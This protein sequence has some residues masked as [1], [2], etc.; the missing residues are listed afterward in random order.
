M[1]ESGKA[2]CPMARNGGNN[3]VRS[4]GDRDGHGDGVADQQSGAGHLRHIG[5]EVVSTDNVGPTGLGIGTDD[6]AVANGDDG[7]DAEDG[8]GDRCDEGEGHQ[9]GNRD[10]NAEN[11]LGGIG[12]GGHDIRRENRQ[13][14]RLTQPLAMQLVVDQR[15]TKQKP[16][17]AVAD[18]LGQVGRR[19][20]RRPDRSVRRR[21]C[22]RRV[23]VSAVSV[24]GPFEVIF[25][26]LAHWGPN[27]K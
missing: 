16:L 1:M 21:G 24:D 23:C 25:D 10:Q 9:S 18:S 11:L 8:P 13:C 4:G 27:A 20:R 5:T 3:G 12:R 19:Q 7:Q 17:D 22:V 2:S 26:C 14:G 15:R 6:V